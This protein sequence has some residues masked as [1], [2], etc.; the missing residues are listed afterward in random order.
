MRGL[1]IEIGGGDDVVYSYLDPD[2]ASDADGDG[3]QRISHEST[4]HCTQTGGFRASIHR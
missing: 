4:D 3:C 1:M 2:P